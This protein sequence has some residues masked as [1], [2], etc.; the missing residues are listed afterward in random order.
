MTEDSDLFGGE[1]RPTDEQ[2]VL[3]SAYLKRHGREAGVRPT[4][5]ELAARG[6]TISVATVQR[7]MAKADVAAPPNKDIPA[8]GATDRVANK[9]D[10]NR[11]LKGEPAKVSLKEIDLKEENLVRKMADILAV[12]N[13]IE[14]NSSTALAI[15]ENRHRMA[16][17]VVIAE[18]MAARPEL[19]LLNMRDTAALVDALTCGAKLSGG[20]SIDIVRLPPG[21]Q[22]DQLN[23]PMKDITPVKSAFAA[24]LEEFRR[25]K[26]ANG[27]GQGA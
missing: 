24:S 12:V 26:R 3:V 16:L 11:R 21:E 14:T 2:V 10:K 17:N 15:M 20:A 6:F 9:R 13:G 27:N 4:Q 25:Q 18:A 7:I 23:P 8:A 22:G 1:G 19:L 5:H